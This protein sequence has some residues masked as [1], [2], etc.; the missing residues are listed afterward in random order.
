MCVP[1]ILRIFLMPLI[2]NVDLI[3]KCDL[4]LVLLF[5]QSFVKLIFFFKNSGYIV[6]D[7]GLGC[8]VQMLFVT[9]VIQLEIRLWLQ[10]FLHDFLLSNSRRFA[11]FVA[12][13][14]TGFSCGV[15]ELCVFQVILAKWLRYPGSCFIQACSCFCKFNLLF[16]KLIIIFSKVIQIVCTHLILIYNSIEE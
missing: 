15:L 13:I 8:Y 14:V 11:L 5:F 7:L 16:S 9:V 2:L 1:L 12:P 3:L 10:G 4:I 6:S